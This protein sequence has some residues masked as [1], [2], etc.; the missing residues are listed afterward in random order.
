MRR[1]RV[2]QET[3]RRRV[4]SCKATYTTAVEIAR[5]LRSTDPSYRRMR[6]QD[7]MRL[8]QETIQSTATNTPPARKQH[9]HDDE[10]RKRRR[11][12]EMEAASRDSSDSASD[13]DEVEGTVASTS[14]FDLLKTNLR[15][16]YKGT[17]SK[18]VVL[19]VTTSTVNND[20]QSKLGW[21]Q[22]KGL[23][24]NSEVGGRAKSYMEFGGM[25]ELLEKL[26]RH[27]LM[28]LC[29]PQ[30]CGEVVMIR[31][32]SGILL[33][34]PPGCGK[35]SL[36]HAIAHETRL[37]FYPVSATDLVSGISGSSEKNVRELFSKA[38]RTAPSIIF[39]DEI[40]SIASKRENSHHGMEKRMVSELLS[41]MGSSKSVLVIGATNWPDAIDG[42]LRRPGRLSHEIYL[43]LPDESAREDILSVL[44]RGMKIDG[45][46]DL[47]K[48][49][50][51]TPGFAAADLVD[52]V[53]QAGVLAMNRIAD[54][55]CSMGEFPEEWLLGTWSQEERDKLARNISD[56]EEAMKLV[57]PSTTRE[58]FSSIPDVKWE[59]VGGLDSLREV[60][61][62]LIIRRIKYPEICQ[63]YGVKLEAGILLYGPPGCGKTLVAKAVANAAG[64]NFIYVEGPELINKFVGES[65]LAV[66]TL[67]RRARTCAPC[68]IFFDEVDALTT[69]C[70]KEGGQ[71]TDRL[72]SQFLVELDGAK[73][74]RGVYV[75][76]ATNWPEK[77]DRIMLRPGRLGT[78]V[79]VPLPSPE[80]RVSILE[81]LARKMPLDSSVDLD[82]IGRMEACEN[83]SGA[84]LSSLLEQAGV[85]AM[86]ED[87]KAGTH[88]TSTIK[89]HHLDVALSKVSPSV[90]DKQRRYYQKLS[91]KSRIG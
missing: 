40:D 85:A 75:I 67:F 74:R 62:D 52:L 88:T 21:K 78:H 24:S 33:H 1:K 64:A 12:Q 47:K 11:T 14:G 84:D 20:D 5:H 37:P 57:K 71:F 81:A 31:G 36:A 60:L 34:G 29:H 58:G 73:Q 17:A 90:S 51:S 79:H 8:V 9:E 72:V 19:E 46:I 54:E 82:A 56:F 53:D 15:E 87:N 76:G 83:M 61:D 27:V 49:A 63:H 80:G 38:H 4:E 10:G 6:Q 23:V 32:I 59:D 66:R 3:L 13:S 30:E 77:V 39:I 69:R 22:F 42:A 45:S 89:A 70:G 16:L 25:K 55:R 48:I 7:L 43:D 91:K 68:I 18:N 2:H 28:P 86:K 65:E 26:N 50:R 35:T 44:T 41:C